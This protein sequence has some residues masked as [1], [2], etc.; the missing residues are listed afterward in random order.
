[1]SASQAGRSSTGAE[2]WCVRAIV[3]RG[4]AN[5]AARKQAMATVRGSLLGRVLVTASIAWATCSSVKAWRLRHVVPLGLGL[6]S[7]VWNARQTHTG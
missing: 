4:I 3:G 7:R 2:R 6:R 1:M 5:P